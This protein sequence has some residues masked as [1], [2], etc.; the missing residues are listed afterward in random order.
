MIGL[1]AQ[2]GSFCYRREEAADWRVTGLENG[3]GR[4]D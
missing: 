2:I 3:V 1:Y 4:T